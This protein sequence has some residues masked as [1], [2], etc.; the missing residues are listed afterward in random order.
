MCVCCA[1]ARARPYMHASMCECMCMY[2]AC[3]SVEGSVGL[4]K[5]AGEVAEGAGEIPPQP[6]LCAFQRGQGSSPLS[7]L[8]LA[9][10][11]WTKR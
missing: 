10:P 7:L 3:V 4:R 6:R 9:F 11:P 1:L 5:C 8:H 2:A